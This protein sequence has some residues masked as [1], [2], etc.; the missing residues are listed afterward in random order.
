M[1][2][3]TRT[4]SPKT[5]PAAPPAVFDITS[6]Y[7]AETLEVAIMDTLV[8]RTADTGMRVVIRSS[9]SAEA[10]DA[11]RTYRATQTIGSDGLSAEQIDDLFLAQLVAVTVSW[12]GFT[13]GGEA[14]PCTPENVRALYAN[15]QAAWIYQQ[16]FGAFMDTARFFETPRAS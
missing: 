11:A 4:Q 2:R 14:I 7:M 3:K 13:S 1:T 5:P 6:R 9:Q 8:D 16:V 15:P 10:R 12:S